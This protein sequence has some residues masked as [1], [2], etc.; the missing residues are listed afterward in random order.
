M[1][2]FLMYCFCVSIAFIAIFNGMIDNL[3]IVLIL[4]ILGASIKFTTILY[5][6]LNTNIFSYVSNAFFIIPIFVGATYDEEG[7]L[8]LYLFSVCGIWALIFVIMH[9]LFRLLENVLGLKNKTS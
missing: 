3:I 2:I 8:L 5:K 9:T 7:N 6:N 4:I 1:A